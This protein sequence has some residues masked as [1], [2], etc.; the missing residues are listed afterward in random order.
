MAMPIGIAAVAGPA[1]AAPAVAGHGAPAVVRHGVPA[2]AAHQPI[3]DGVPA[4][5]GPAVVRAEPGQLDAAEQAV[6]RTGGTV[7]RRLSSLD[8][9][10]VTL[11]AGAA[12]R[13]GG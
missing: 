9:L 3:V 10:T 4:S 11:P 7:V 6:R 2:V 12:A 5:G 8:T 13:V 1:A